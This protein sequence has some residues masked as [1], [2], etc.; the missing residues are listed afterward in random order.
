[1]S[2]CC[3]DTYTR[4]TSFLAVILALALCL[5][6]VYA[7]ALPEDRDQPMHITADKAERDDIHGITTY[8]G[9]VVL[10][11]GTLRL[12]SQKL[13][14]H[15]TD[16]DPSEIIAEGNPAKMQERPEADKAIVYADAA[17]I[18]YYRSEQRV[19]LQT[20]GHVEQDGYVV[21]GDSIDYFI[22][23]QLIKA[24][25]DQTRAGD[26]VNVVIPPSVTNKKDDS[27]TTKSE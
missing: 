16:E 25:S 8:T 13:T 15:H 3:P 9:N 24:E 17:V 23:K 7:R 20:D 10:I 5:C 14:I 26:K 21:K 4:S 11:Q 1:M 18:T 12:E 27:G 19:H 6:P 2:I 22:D